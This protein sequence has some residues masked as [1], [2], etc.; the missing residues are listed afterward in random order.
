MALEIETPFDEEF[1]VS[2]MY[3]H[4]LRNFIVLLELMKTTGK[5]KVLIISVS[6]RLLNLLMEMAKNRKLEAVWF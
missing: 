6:A 5:K 4:F 3:I 2:F 1:L